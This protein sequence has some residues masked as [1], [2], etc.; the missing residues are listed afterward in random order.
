MKRTGIL[1]GSF[2]PVH[3]GHLM[4]A[5]WMAQ[6]AGFDRVW[7][8][9]SPLNPLKADHADIIA[10][11]GHRRAMLEIAVAGADALRM[12]DIELSMPRPSYMIDTLELL[13]ARHPDTSFGLIIGSDNWLV[14]DR[15]RNHREIIRRFGVTI[16]PRP[17]YEVDAAS[18]PD[19][20]RLIDAPTAD[21]SSTLLRGAIKAGA[22]LNYFMPPGV[23][24]YIKEHNL[25]TD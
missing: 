25:Y 19:G 2:N 7:L 11:D 23:F 12:C 17:G 1:G 14:F 20:V 5:Q 16:Y 8:S 15:W 22:N 9:L 4:V 6:F 18:L 24:N 21:I 10:A 3:I 13:S